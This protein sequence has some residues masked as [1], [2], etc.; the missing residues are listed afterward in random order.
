MKGSQTFFGETNE[1]YIYS[2]THDEKEVVWRRRKKID[3]YEVRIE[4]DYEDIAVVPNLM[5][6][7]VVNS[8]ELLVNL[9]ATDDSKIGC[10]REDSIDNH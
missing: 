5:G 9:L 3:S 6:E 4:T 10:C 2:Q 1:A 8:K 7:M